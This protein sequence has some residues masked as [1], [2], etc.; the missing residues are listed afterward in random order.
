MAEQVGPLTQDDINQL[1]EQLKT[2]TFAESEIR[3]AESAGIDMTEQKA[4][5]KD[6]KAQLLRIKNTYA[7]GR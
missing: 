3:K 1:N 6:T 7:P 4:Q 5:L 2:V